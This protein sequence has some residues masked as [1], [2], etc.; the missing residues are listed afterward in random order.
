MHDYKVGKSMANAIFMFLFDLDGTLV[1]SSAAILGAYRSAIRAVLGYD[2]QPD[3]EHVRDLLRRRPSEY[4]RQHYP[5]VADVLTEQYAAQYESKSVII[6]SGIAELLEGLTSRGPLGIVSNKGRVRINSDLIQ[7]DVN[8]A[9]FD[10]VVGAEDTIE[11]KPH[12]API[13]KALE[14]QG[15]IRRTAVYV[16]DGPH[17]M[18]AAKAAGLIAIGVTW[19][20]Y[21]ASALVASGADYMVEHVEALSDLLQ[22]LAL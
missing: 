12:P 21:P 7:V 10:V 2:I 9:I 17:D 4:F 15:A 18:H 6:Y 1:D 5:P 13:L 20:Y 22:N 16:G 11:R 3:E 8:P 14:I 19:G